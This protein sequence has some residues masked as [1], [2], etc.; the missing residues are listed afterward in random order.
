MQALE[1]ALPGIDQNWPKNK[2]NMDA[3][4]TLTVEQ[5]A[6]MLLCDKETV[7]ERL[8]RG[9]LP[10]LKFG[11]SWVIPTAALFQRLN[12]LALEEAACRKKAQSGSAVTHPAAAPTKRGRKRF[13][14]QHT[15]S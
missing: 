2:K 5:V 9:D 14:A 7:A 10:G 13:T 4:N 12:D 8:N 1:T 6:E 3:K 11:R 15:A